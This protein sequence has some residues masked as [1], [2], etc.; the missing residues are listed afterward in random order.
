MAQYN[1]IYVFSDEKQI[2]LNTMIN[3]IK[4]ESLFVY[5]QN[6]RI[7]IKISSIRCFNVSFRRLRNCLCV[8]D[9]YHVLKILVKNINNTTV[10]KENENLFYLNIKTN[11]PFGNQIFMSN[12][13]IK[14][15]EVVDFIEFYKN[16]DY[17]LIMEKQSKKITDLVNK[18]AEYEKKYK[19]PTTEDELILMY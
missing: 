15:K 16:D 13:K 14:I 10:V 18:I 19:E 9:D 4:N 2:L 17:K 5:L 6:K 7:F 1:D 3:G 12:T 8:N 11:K